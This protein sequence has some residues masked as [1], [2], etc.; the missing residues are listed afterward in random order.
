MLHDLDTSINVALDF[1]A[2]AMRD[3]GNW[4]ILTHAAM[5]V[6]V[7][8]D[9][10]KDEERYVFFQ[11]PLSLRCIGRNSSPKCD[12][13]IPSKTTTTHAHGPTTHSA[14]LAMLHA[15]LVDVFP[16]AKI[17]QSA[18]RLLNFGD[19]L[20]AIDVGRR[21]LRESKWVGNI[22]YTVVTSLDSY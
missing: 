11:E 8:W 13:S 14:S 1:P 3:S 16:D 2:G 12:T 19:T 6:F 20:N 18:P 4:G 10:C 15:S 9:Q 5:M 22:M 21:K 7:G 17:L